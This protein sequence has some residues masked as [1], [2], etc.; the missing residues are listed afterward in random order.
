MKILMGFLKIVILNL[1]CNVMRKIWR[2]DFVRMI[3]KK[4]NIVG[5]GKLLGGGGLNIFIF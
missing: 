4:I 1:K 3:I 2:F 5:I